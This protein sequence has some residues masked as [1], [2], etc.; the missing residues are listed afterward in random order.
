VRPQLPCRGR[1]AAAFAA[2]AALVVLALPSVALATTGSIEGLSITPDLV[3]A[4]VSSL[5]V[6]YDECTAEVPDCTWTATAMLAPP[7]RA[8]CTP[9]WSVLEEFEANPPGLPDPPP[10][11][12]R[13]R[14]VWGMEFNGNGVRQSGPLTFGLEGVDDFRLCLYATHFSSP[15]VYPPI[16]P[17]NL[18]AESLLHV[19]LPPSEETQPASPTPPLAC[20][21]HQVRRHGKCV[22][23]ARRYHHRHHERGN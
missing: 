18:I 14:H 22:K 12:Y 16:E 19:D 6:F 1:R 10:G 7:Q 13:E 4:S 3:T 2:F 5:D 17:P 15:P 21:K 20:K 9:M 23:K 8:S 11:F